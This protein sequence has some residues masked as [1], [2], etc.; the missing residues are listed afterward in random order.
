M[1]TSPFRAGKELRARCQ[2]TRS[3]F[4]AHNRGP[5]V[6]IGGAQKGQARQR[7]VVAELD[8]PQR[9]FAEW[10]NSRRPLV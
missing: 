7:D 9:V 5:G 8:A 4:A 6:D 10:A 2:L 3:A 1:S